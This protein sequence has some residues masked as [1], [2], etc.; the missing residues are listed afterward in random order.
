MKTALRP[1]FL[2][3]ALGLALAPLTSSAEPHWIWTQKGAKG[4]E[5]ATFKTKF[6]VKGT[7]KSAT[8]NFTCDNGAT[9]FVNGQ[10]A[11]VNPDWQE[12]AKV[13]VTKLVQSGEN[14]LRFDAQNKDGVAALVATL[15]LEAQN[16][17]VTTIES[18]PEWL[19]AR[20]GQH[21]FQARG[22]DRDVWR[23]TVGQGAHARQRDAEGK[24]RTGRVGG[25]GFAASAGGLQGRAALHGAEGGAGFVG[26]DDG[27][28]ERP[29]DRGRSI[30]RPLP[31][32]GAADRHDGRGEGGAA[33]LPMAPTANRSAARTGCSTPSTAST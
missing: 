29:A 15:T 21:G 20:D 1:R 7:L 13:D 14:E 12:R 25:P 19:A 10:K 11:G 26:L 5:K 30:R 32:D 18:G 27:G 17:K 33:P 2:L 23:R 28:L 3:I 31:R 4:G 6:E 9:A 16:G 8:L 22:V 24:R